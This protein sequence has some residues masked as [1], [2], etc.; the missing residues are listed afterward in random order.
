MISRILLFFLLMCHLTC[1]VTLSAEASQTDVGLWGD[2]KFAQIISST[3]HLDKPGERIVA[4]SSH[5]INSP[6][7]TDTLVGGPEEP[8]QLVIN[9]SE[10]DCFT[11]L[12]VVE[13]MRRSTVVGDF[14]EQLR[15]VRYRNGIVA[16]AARRHF[17]SDWVTDDASP[18]SDVT[19]SV[20]KGRIKKVVKQLNFKS[21]GSHWLPGI[22]VTQREIHYI[23]GSMINASRPLPLLTGDYVGI[24][25]EHAG[26]DV[27]HTGLIV[28]S[29]DS[30]MIRHASS[31]S[32]VE[33][34]IDEELLEYLQ[35]KAG[36]V[37]Y[38]VNP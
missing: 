15:K 36:L 4:L 1:N 3:T 37:V 17:F 5:F 2:D 27:S 14:P 23:P 11:F 6:Y 24:Y 33:R 35:G 7:A 9:L 26:L 10:F 34:V 30:I 32:G 22:A 21:D 31:L 18:V 8:E 13:A 20:G 29:K 19:S 16:Y 38:R 12:D 28:K 25:S